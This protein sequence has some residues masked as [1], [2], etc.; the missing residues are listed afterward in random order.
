[1]TV[2]QASMGRIRRRIKHDRM[3]IPE[4]DQHVHRR[5]LEKG[6]K[7]LHRRRN[8]LKTGRINRQVLS[9]VTAALLALSMPVSAAAAS[10]TEET[11]PVSMENQSAQESSVPAEEPSE[12]GREIGSLKERVKSLIIIYFR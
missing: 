9:F 1:M 7:D 5:Q 6:H 12:A 11:D 8:I 10:G 2:R 4:A 3:T